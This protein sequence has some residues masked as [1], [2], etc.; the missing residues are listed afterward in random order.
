[1]NIKKWL[2]VVVFVL[3]TVFAGAA[4][5]EGNVA[6]IGTTEY[7]TFDAAL[8]KAQDG[9]TIVLL[10]NAVTD[11]GINLSNKLTVDGGASKYKLTF[12]SE[13]IALQSGSSLTFQNCTVEM[14]GIGATPYV[15]WNWMG[16]SAS[17]A[18]LN[19]TNVQMT[20]DGTG[21][22]KDS[23]HGIYMSNSGKVNMT[24]SCLEIRNYPQ[25]AL[26]WNGGSGYD[27]TLENSTFIAEKNRSG[28][29]GTF[30][31]KA[32]NST[33]QVVNNSGNGSNGS[34]FD[35][36]NC[37]VEFN[38]N[39]GIGIS[40]SDLTLKDSTLN[41]KNNAINGVTFA[42]TGSFI[43]SKV[44]ITGT[45]G[46]YISKF[47]TY[48][49][50]MSVRANAVGS[51]DA[52][53]TLTI[54]DNM[55]TGLLLVEGSSLTIAEGAQVSILRNIADQRNCTT[56]NE[57]AQTGG[58]V[59]VGKNA[60][61][62]LNSTASIYNN[63]ALLAGDDLYVENG[64]KLTF[65][66]TGS[67]WKLDG[68]PDCTDA[69]NGWYDDAKDA[70][71]EAHAS[72]AQNHIVLVDAGAYEAPLALKAAHGV[73]PPAPTAAPVPQTGD[74]TPLHVLYALLALS[75]TAALV[76]TLRRKAQR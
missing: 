57:L 52:K 62:T 9:D 11:K 55:A 74:H 24:N 3:L 22:T 76:L 15:G 48:S 27:F 29:A 5:A 54:E 2:P 70:R 66:K 67:G 23:T 28:L 10:Q 18:E 68:D 56:K 53:T 8:D 49:A 6:K 21:I 30:Y 51:I 36:D 25:D 19:L 47:G 1:M 32:K 50:G 58:G 45:I 63:H 41:A 64:G 46:N 31:V 12:A 4:L 35:F 33:F 37:Q 71:W 42:G 13:G 73:L 69:I 60:S 61:A 34:H 40:A 65:G 43:N 38:G 39:G 20:M 75:L 26:E 59:R 16:I 44:T 17:N 72:D 7:A 14:T